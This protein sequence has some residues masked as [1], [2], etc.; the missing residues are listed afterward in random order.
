MV[1]LREDRKLSPMSGQRLK[2]VGHG[3]LVAGLLREKSFRIEAVVRRNADK[4]AGRR[5]VAIGCLG[6]AG[7]QRFEGWDSERKP[8]TTQ[9]AATVELALSLG[10]HGISFRE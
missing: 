1:E 2:A 6:P 8:G 7:S 4:V 5:L 3:I 10:C 9:E